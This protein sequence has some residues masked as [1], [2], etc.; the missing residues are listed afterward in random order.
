MINV[1]AQGHNAVTPVRLE[2]VAP[3]SRVKHSTTEPLHPWY[4][5]HLTGDQHL[6]KSHFFQL[7]HACICCGYSMTDGSLEHTKH[8]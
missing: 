5:R 8:V 1:L 3:P 6:V 2:P 7:T 4:T